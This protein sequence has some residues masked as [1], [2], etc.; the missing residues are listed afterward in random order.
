MTMLVNG[1]F[2]L[3]HSL[4]YNERRVI[5]PFARIQKFA[6]SPLGH[7]YVGEHLMAAG[8]R[9]IVHAKAGGEK[10]PLPII[11]RPQQMVV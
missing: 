2:A 7:E 11:L 10:D 8:L 1:A 5:G 3:L 9:A 4:F 6:V